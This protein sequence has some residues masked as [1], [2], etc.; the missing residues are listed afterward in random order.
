MSC[1]A[2]SLKARLAQLENELLMSMCTVTDDAAVG[3][4]ILAFAD[5]A[6]V[7][8]MASLLK[9][10]LHR[11]PDHM[12]AVVQGRRHIGGRVTVAPAW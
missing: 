7:A 3:K 9:Q 5:K 12:E 8:A 4:T 10:D 1:A 11:L 6:D 2:A